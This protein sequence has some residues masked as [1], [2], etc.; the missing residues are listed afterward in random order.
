MPIESRFE[1]VLSLFLLFVIGVIFSNLILDVVIQE[2]GLIADQLWWLAII[3]RVRVWRWW[4]EPRGISLRLWAKAYV[5]IELLVL[6]ACAS[7]EI[8]HVHFARSQRHKVWVI[9]L[10]QHLRSLLL[11]PLLKSVNIANIC[12]SLWSIDGIPRG[13]ADVSLRWSSIGVIF[14]IDLLDSLAQLK[15]GVVGSL[16]PRAS[17]VDNAQISRLAWIYLLVSIVYSESRIG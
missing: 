17:F 10:L 7:I 12:G 4:S 11:L 9:R 6:C 16:L 3:S 14:A 15:V 1:K 8:I 5:W 2:V 13:I